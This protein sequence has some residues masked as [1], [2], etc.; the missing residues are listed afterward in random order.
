M[1]PEAVQNLFSTY[2]TSS[3]IRESSNKLQD[4]RQL[5]T[6]DE[7]E[8]STRINDLAYR[9]GN[10][11]DEVAKTTFFINGLHPAIRSIVARFRESQP[12]RCVTFDAIVHYARDEGDAY[13]ARQPTRNLPTRRSSPAPRAVHFIEDARPQDEEQLLLA[14]EQSDI[15][16]QLPST[17]QSEPPLE[18]EQLFVT[19][20]TRPATPIAYGDRNS[21][22]NRVGWVDR[23]IPNRKVI[24]YRC[25][26]FNSHISPDCKVKFS[27]Y[28]III[29]NFEILSQNDR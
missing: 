9:C 25:Y 10:V 22:P 27:D 21:T 20:R 23:G 11:H 28:E 1:W 24:C 19:E 16:S 2:A 6:E 12:R 4:T 29:K 26:E 13:R 8:Y 7:R 17:L 15:T 14:P 18:H 5:A 3:A